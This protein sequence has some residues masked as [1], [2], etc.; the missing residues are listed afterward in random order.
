MKRRMIIGAIVVVVILGL[1]TYSKPLS[2]YKAVG[3]GGDIGIVLNT[4][5]IEDGTPHIDSEN[6][7]AITTAQKDQFLA[8]TQKYS[9][10]RTLNTLFSDG[11]VTDI[12]DQ[13]LSIYLFDE[14]CFYN[15]FISSSGKIVVNQKRYHM[16]GAETFIQEMVAILEDRP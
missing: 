13:T 14:D 1:M 11:G 9:Y 4:F 8:L 7:S 12:G 6:Y 15:V 10:Q 3:K 16:K 5:T 2:L